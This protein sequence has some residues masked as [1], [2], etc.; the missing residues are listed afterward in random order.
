MPAGPLP[1][2]LGEFLA[3]PNPAVIATLRHDG[4]PRTVATRYLWENGRVL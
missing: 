2:E 1:L 3:Q 4:S